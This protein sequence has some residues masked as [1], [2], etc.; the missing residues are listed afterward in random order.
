VISGAD[1]FQVEGIARAKVLRV[2][3]VLQDKWKTEEGMEERN[4]RDRKVEIRH[5][6]ACGLG[7]DSGNDTEGHQEPLEV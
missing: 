4:G 6:S 1:A 2:L 3:V 5:R 7:E